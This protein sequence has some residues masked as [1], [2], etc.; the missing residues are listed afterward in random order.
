MPLKFLLSCKVF[1]HDEYFSREI[2]SSSADPFVTQKIATKWTGPWEIPYLNIFQTGILTSVI[3][4]RRFRMII[5]AS[6][7]LCRSEKYCLVQYLLRPQE[8]WEFD[9]NNG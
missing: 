8:A 3:L 9:E 6:I 5:P 2:F 4:S 1:I 7:Y